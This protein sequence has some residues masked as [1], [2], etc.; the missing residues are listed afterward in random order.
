[1]SARRHGD[2]QSDMARGKIDVGGIGEQGPVRYGVGQPE[3]KRGGW[4]MGVGNF[5]FSA[6]LERNGGG[7]AQEQAR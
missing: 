1:M 7:R 5:E 4:G 6:S 3:R 2:H